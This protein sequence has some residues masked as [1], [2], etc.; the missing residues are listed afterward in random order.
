LSDE[1]SSS[2]L[3]LSEEEELGHDEEIDD[4][5]APLVEEER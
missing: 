2:S 1:Y 5:T 3:V 4:S